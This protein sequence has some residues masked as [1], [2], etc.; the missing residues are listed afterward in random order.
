VSYWT[1]RGEDVTGGACGMQ[2]DVANFN[3]TLTRKP[4][5]KGILRRF[6]YTRDDNIALVNGVMNFW[7]P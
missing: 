6:K 3:R 5:M 2:T 7:V 1:S 4:E